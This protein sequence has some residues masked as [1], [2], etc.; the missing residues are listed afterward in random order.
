MLMI[1]P[2]MV[3]HLRAGLY[4][5]LGLTAEEIA[6]L[7]LR[8]RAPAAAPCQEL[9]LRVDAL[10]ALLDTIGWDAEQPTP[11]V[12]VDLGA[13]RALVLTVL[14]RQLDTEVDALGDIPSARRHEAERRAGEL[15]EFIADL[16]RLPGHQRARE[17][18]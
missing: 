9:L 8:R 10:R 3:E 5:E 15:R 2:V 1:A 13:H 4:D 12:R 18:R 17:R 14:Q 11:R 6:E 7:S 16:Q